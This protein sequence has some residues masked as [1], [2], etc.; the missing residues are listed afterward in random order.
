MTRSTLASLRDAERRKNDVERL[1]CAR[2]AKAFDSHLP[3]RFENRGGAKAEVLWV[4]TQQRLKGLE[5]L[6]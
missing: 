3:H 2:T 1:H 4:N 6:P 5:P